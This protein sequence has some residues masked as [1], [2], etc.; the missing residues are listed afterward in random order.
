MV[1]INGGTTPLKEKLV[2]KIVQYGLKALDI[3]IKESIDGVFSIL[4]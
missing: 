3:V 4:K 2:I 1:I